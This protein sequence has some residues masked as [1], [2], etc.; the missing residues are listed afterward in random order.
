MQFTITVPRADQAKLAAEAAKLGHVAVHPVG[1]QAI[2]LHELGSVL[3]LTGSTDSDDVLVVVENP[4]H[5]EDQIKTA[6]EADI[7]KLLAA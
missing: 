3:T 7:L 1:P 2:V 6:L 5:T 4:T